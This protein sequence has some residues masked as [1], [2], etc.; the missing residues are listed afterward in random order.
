MPTGAG[1]SLCYQLPALLL[2]GRDAG[3]LAA[4]RAD[5]GPVRQAARA[6]HRGRAA[7]Q[8]GPA[9]RPTPPRR[10]SPRARAKIV[11]TTPERL[12]DAEF[13]ASSRSA[14]PD[15]PARRRRGAL[16]LAVGPRLPPGVPRDRRRAS[17]G[18]AQPTVLALTATATDAVIDDIARQL[19]V[20]RFE[21][22][23]TGVYR[24]NL[25]YRVLQVTNEDDKLARAVASCAAAPG[26]GSSTPPRSR[27][28]R[29]ST[30]RSCEARHVGRPLSRQ[31]RRGRATRA[32]G[33]VHGRPAPASWSRPTP[34]ASASTRPTPAS[35]CTTRCPAGSTPTTRSRVAPAAT[36]TTA[37]CTLLFL[38]SDKA[39]QQFFLAGKYPRARTWPPS[40]ARCSASRG[41]DGAQPWTLAAPAG[42]ARPAQGQAAGRAA[43]A[44]PPG[45]RRARIAKAA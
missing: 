11:F 37:D 40:T 45:R 10:R 21:V 2:P 14:A 43:P 30:R 26:A 41:D 6:R 8:R 13:L 9:A 12:A 32:A 39:V 19:G 25:H 31:A 22:I 18:S 38:H 15:Q 34:S 33:R 1:K 27:A 20:G 42:G 24:P 5:E 4:D 7:Q 16:H 44:A 36:A 23:N 29:P 17:S 3:R 35:S 28:P